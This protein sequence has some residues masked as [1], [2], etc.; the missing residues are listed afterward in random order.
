M[1]KIKNYILESAANLLSRKAASIVVWLLFASTVV[2][3]FIVDKNYFIHFIVS[4]LVNQIFAFLIFGTGIL[5]I[6]NMYLTKRFPKIIDDFKLRRDRIYFL[7]EAQIYNVFIQWQI[8]IATKPI[9]F[10]S[11][12][13]EALIQ[14][15]ILSEI[16]YI[17]MA[18]NEFLVKF[19]SDLSNEDFIDSNKI[20]EHLYKSL[21]IDRIE[22]DLFKSDSFVNR[23][24][25]DTSVSMPIGKKKEILKNIPNII[26]QK[27]KCSCSNFNVFLRN[28]INECER[29]SLSRHDTI[30]LLLSYL[31][32]CIY[33][34]KDNILPNFVN[35]FN[36]DLAH[37]NLL[38]DGIPLISKEH[39]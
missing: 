18:L 28:C 30:S 39:I 35:E 8:D 34:Y 22:F 17:E 21:I 23:F 10:N 29:R 13:K 15:F 38:F 14:D 4:T 9:G 6:V 11:I 25:I 16:G 32:I 5:M 26:I 36:G 12:G 37:Y 3:Y 7:K 33:S 2:A 20:C 31:V 27:Y 24:S 19:Y 1:F